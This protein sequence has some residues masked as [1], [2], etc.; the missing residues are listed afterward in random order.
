MVIFLLNV[1]SLHDHDVLNQAFG[2]YFGSVAGLN[3]GSRLR[4]TP[5][6][7]IK[8]KVTS[9]H[10]I[11]LAWLALERNDMLAGLPRDKEATTGPRPIEIFSLRSCMNCFNC[12]HFFGSARR[13]TWLPI[14]VP[15]HFLSFAIH[16]TEDL[17][18][19]CLCFQH[20]TGT[21]RNPFGS[22][23]RLVPLA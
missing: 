11:P 21:A 2:A 14:I 16:D 9:A 18:E 19:S 3:D 22:H 5:W 10:D 12:D 23:K 8:L 1:P 13:P 17:I 15:A 6:D 20:I 7:R 4:L